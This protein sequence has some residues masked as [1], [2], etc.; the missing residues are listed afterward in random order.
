M[1]G[2]LEKG[3]D[4]KSKNH[5]KRNRFTRMCIGE[6][7][8]LLMKSNTFDSI[9]VSMLVKKA[10]ISRMTFYHYYH[11]KRDV[12]SNYLSEI[13]RTYIVESSKSGNKFHDY[14]NILFTLNYFDQYSD[15]LICL[16]NAGMYSLIIDAL[17]E[18]MEKYIIP[19]KKNE[20]YR[21]YYYAGALLNVFLK[22]ESDGKQ[23][24]AESIADI[25]IKSL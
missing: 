20:E 14:N 25:L 21:I 15:L 10:G 2:F 5:T 22:W 11:D 4:N 23:E 17:N 6:S 1:N 9:T 24:P 18:Y 13:I 7:L 8:V 19:H 12:L 3:L 16:R